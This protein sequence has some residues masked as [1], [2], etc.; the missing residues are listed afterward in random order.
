MACCWNPG[1]SI[2]SKQCV[3]TATT[4]VDG[5]HVCRQHSETFKGTYNRSDKTPETH[6]F[7]CQGCS[8]DTGHDVFHPEISSIHCLGSVCGTIK[9]QCF[10]KARHHQE[11]TESKPEVSNTT[12]TFEPTDT[13]PVTSPTTP[14]T[15]PS[16]PVVSP[17]TPVAS[18]STET[19]QISPLSLSSPSTPVTTPSFTGLTEILDVSDIN[20]DTNPDNWVK[21][22]LDIGDGS[23]ENEYWTKVDG[24]QLLIYSNNDEESDREFIGQTDFPEE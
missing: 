21:Q 11:F 10:S 24:D 9:P 2:K 12:I 22:R 19:E 14:V 18:P 4:E 16:T 7:F 15:S 17:S 1:F 23:G 20:L 3:K 6:P 8:K 13:E 5:V